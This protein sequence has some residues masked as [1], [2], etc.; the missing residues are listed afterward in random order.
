MISEEQWD[1]LESWYEEKVL[2]QAPTIMPQTTSE[3]KINEDEKMSD[4]ESDT[5]EIDE[6]T[7]KS[8][9]EYDEMDVSKDEIDEN[10]FEKEELEVRKDEMNVPKQTNNDVLESIDKIINKGIPKIINFESV[11]IDPLKLNKVLI[12]TV[13]N[14]KNEIKIKM[15]FQYRRVLIPKKTKWEI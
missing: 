6:E 13:P 9:D 7:E 1:A 5:V 11:N 12:N 4:D 14:R 15:T 3:I 2:N 8:K 10:E